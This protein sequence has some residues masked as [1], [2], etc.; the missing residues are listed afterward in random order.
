MPKNNHLITCNLAGGDRGFSFTMRNRLPNGILPWFTAA[1]TRKPH[2]IPQKPYSYGFCSALLTPPSAAGAADFRPLRTP[3]GFRVM[4]SS[5]TIAT[6]VMACDLVA[7]PSMMTSTSQ[8][9]LPETNK[10]PADLHR[11]SPVADG[12]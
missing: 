3:A 8:R 5:H 1:P 11:Q 6:E 12:S 9:S 2:S 4:V 7:I 10:A